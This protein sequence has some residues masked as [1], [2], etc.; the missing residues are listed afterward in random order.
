M[1]SPPK[2]LLSLLDFSEESKRVQEK[3][4]LYHGLR[5][6]QK[7]MVGPGNLVNNLVVKASL[8]SGKIGL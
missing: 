5:S 7:G 3:I 4:D 6:S 2:S 1:G 8:S